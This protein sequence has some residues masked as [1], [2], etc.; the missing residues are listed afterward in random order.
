MFSALVS[1]PVVAG[2]NHFENG[3]AEFRS[4]ALF[5]IAI[6]A[7]DL[8]AAASAVARHLSSDN[9]ATV[10]HKY[11][12]PQQKEKNDVS[13]ALSQKRPL[14][15]GDQI[16]GIFEL[17][18]YDFQLL[19][20][21]RHVGRIGILDQL[22]GFVL[23]IANVKGIEHDFLFFGQVGDVMNFFRKFSTVIFFVRIDLRHLPQSFDPLVNAGF[24]FRIDFGVHFIQVIDHIGIFF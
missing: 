5:H 6:G 9:A 19:E 8:F 3:T 10:K 12:D 16:G 1:T 21:R 14:F 18:F 15:A 7:F 24:Q 22:L 17:P 13:R 2:P 23:E 11:Q 4:A 20:Q